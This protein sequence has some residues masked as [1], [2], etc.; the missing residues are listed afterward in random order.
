MAGSVSIRAIAAAIS[1]FTSSIPEARWLAPA[2]T[3]A[4]PP[5][6][7]LLEEVAEARSV[8]PSTSWEVAVV[9]EPPVAAYALLR[10]VWAPLTQVPAPA[11]K[12]PAP[13]A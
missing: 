13:V 12:F 11:A 4:A 1:E 8:A 3:S 5:A 6:S 2:L 10:Q 7:V 9:S